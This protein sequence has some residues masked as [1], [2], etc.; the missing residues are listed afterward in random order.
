VD[1]LKAGEKEPPP[2]ETGEAA[3]VR[4]M[5]ESFA[6]VN[7]AGTIKTEQFGEKSLKIPEVRV[8]NLGDRQTGLTPQQLTNALMSS[9]MKQVQQAVGAYLKN[10]AKDAA[11]E[12][13][14]KQIDEKIGAEN[15]EKLEGL[16]GLLKKN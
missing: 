1:R 2:A 4:L 6:F 16:K 13:L 12:E 14:N 9:V 15:R 5:L 3:D 8:S 10:L 11:K 7:S